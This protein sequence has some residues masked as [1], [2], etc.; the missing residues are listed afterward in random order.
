MRI[1]EAF[2]SNFL[3]VDDL[4]G[5]RIIVTM[6]RIE[7]Q[8]IG[9]DT[10]PVLFFQ[11]KDKGLVLNKTNAITIAEITGTEEMDNWRGQKIVLHPDKT[12]YEGKRVAC[13]RIAEA[14]AA[15]GQRQPDPSPDPDEMSDSFEADADGDFA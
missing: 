3:K 10:K 6:D 11:G 8:K 15:A 9:D 4:K 2:P 12:M 5:K 1:G 14:P 13:I 7:V